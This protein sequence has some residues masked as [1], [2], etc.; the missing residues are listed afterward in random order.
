M[1]SKHLTP[2]D[3]ENWL[4][5]TRTKVAEERYWIVFTRDLYTGFYRGIDL[6]N[7]EADEQYF[8]EVTDSWKNEH[9]YKEPDPESETPAQE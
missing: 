8:E 9:E 6:A 4:L 7:P 5:D 1:A 3:P 2:K